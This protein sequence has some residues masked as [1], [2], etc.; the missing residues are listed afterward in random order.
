[1][2]VGPAKMVHS[3][4]KFGGEKV[5]S[6]VMSVIE[7][8]SSGDSSATSGNSGRVSR[9]PISPSRKT[10][11]S[12]SSQELV[13]DTLGSLTTLLSVSSATLIQ[14]T[15]TIVSKKIAGGKLQNK[16]KENQPR[17]N[18]L[19]RKKSSL[20]TLSPEDLGDVTSNPQGASPPAL[21]VTLP[22]SSQSSTPVDKYFNG[23]SGSGHKSPT[24]AVS[25][26]SN[27][28]PSTFHL[29]KPISSYRNNSNNSNYNNHK[30]NS[31]IKNIRPIASSRTSTSVGGQFKDI[32]KKVEGQRSPNY[33]AA[34]S[35]GNLE[36]LELHN[37]SNNTSGV[38][39]RNAE[40]VVLQS[41]INKSNTTD[42]H[43]DKNKRRQQELNNH[44]DDDN[45]GDSCHGRVCVHHYH[46]HSHHHHYH[47]Y[48]NNSIPSHHTHPS[49]STDNKN[50]HKDNQPQQQNN[51]ANDRLNPQQPHLH[52][53]ND[54]SMIKSTANQSPPPAEQTSKSPP[55][56]HEHPDDISFYRKFSAISP[57][58]SK[59]RSKSSLEW[60]VA[61]A[62]TTADLTSLNGRA[63]N[64][65][66][67]SKAKRQKSRS[68]PM[69]LEIVGTSNITGGVEYPYGCKCGGC[70]FCCNELSCDCCCDECCC[71]RQFSHLTTLVDNDE[72]N[73]D[74][75][76][77]TTSSL[78]KNTSSIFKRIS[79]SLESL[80]IGNDGH[81]VINNHDE[82][83][84]DD[85]DDDD[86]FNDPDSFIDA[87][88]LRHLEMFDSDPDDMNDV[89]DDK[90]LGT[91]YRDI[92]D[93]GQVHRVSIKE[94]NAG[95]PKHDR[96]ASTAAPDDNDG[97]CKERT[98][99]VGNIHDRAG[100]ASAAAITTD[101][102]TIPRKS[103][104]NIVIVR[105][106]PTRSSTDYQINIG[107]GSDRRTSSSTGEHHHHRRK[108]S[109]RNVLRTANGEIRSS[110]ITPIH[111]SG[112]S[113]ETSGARTGGVVVVEEQT[114]R[115]ALMTVSV[116]T[117][118]LFLDAIHLQMNHG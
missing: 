6:F 32:D 51:I 87:H 8:A 19:R 39:R 43:N 82:G 69:K 15:D 35:K 73:L 103:N 5:E 11:R 27:D 86:L 100:N 75:R 81:V 97:N 45:V 34:D 46:H 47:Y 23:I 116:D 65:V 72:P 91:N 7:A 36:P 114:R 53:H 30:S 59:R 110:P 88:L 104:G 37:N 31:E 118:S 77:H 83:T 96:T 54:Q 94:E 21:L 68:T 71:A 93:P 55:P 52:Y 98:S 113:N 102:G 111:L 49:L 57:V 115:S 25:P 99:S 10:T 13:E 9:Y 85:D 101:N 22:S 105:K 89:D 29:R 63:V 64:G 109:T 58:Y 42:E 26:S 44:T 16:K 14:S 2:P 60:A 74:K 12:Q 62:E 95:A 80:N 18:I 3:S 92:Y 61:A 38:S 90:N 40:D 117:M 108:R 50:Q 33:T 28:H 24:S 84:D 56:S 66:L 107:D 4:K 76:R 48:D 17:K 67:C 78:G 1:M 106:T 41:S 20:K 79:R 112:H 70:H